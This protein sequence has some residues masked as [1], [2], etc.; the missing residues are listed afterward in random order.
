MSITL[1]GTTGITS[2]GDITLNNG[3]ADGAQVTLTSSGYSNWNLDNY[4]GRFRA[5]YNATEYFT[6]DTSGNVGIGTASPATKLQVVGASGSL[7][8][9]INAGNT[10]LDITSNDATGVTDVATSPLGAGGKV[11]TFTTYNGSSSAERMRIDSSG[12]VGIGT[13]SPTYKLDISSG[14]SN[15]LNITTANANTTIFNITR[16][17]V[18]TVTHTLDNTGYKIINGGSGGLY[19]GYT[20][21]SWTSLSDER[22]KT[23]LKPIENAVEKVSTLRAVTGRFKTDNENKSRA[24]LIAQDI[25]AVLPEAVDTSNPEQLGVSY[26]DTIPLLVAAIK[27]QQTII[28]DLKARVTAL[29]ASNV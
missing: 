3:N 17:S 5:Y 15:T 22:F 16:T 23:D 12:N 2:S 8:A 28:N 29:E 20:G 9:R 10:G 14:S 18:T 13:S 11:M 25:Q 27:E 21:T 7:N 24:F 4:S 6:I 26:T 19:L 1:N